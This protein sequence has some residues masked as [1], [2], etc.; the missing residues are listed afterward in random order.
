[1]ITWLYEEIL[2]IDLGIVE[3]EIKT[4]LDAKHVPQCLCAVNPRKETNIKEEIEKLLKVGFIY[5]VPLMK[6][7]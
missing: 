7:V 2:G 4:Y 5:V 3:H 1:M 6:W